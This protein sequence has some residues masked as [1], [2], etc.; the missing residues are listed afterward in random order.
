MG[1]MATSVLASQQRSRQEDLASLDAE[2]KRLQKRWGELAS[3]S[4]S[5]T[6]ASAQQADSELASNSRAT[7]IG[8]DLM[9]DADSWPLSTDQPTNLASSAITRRCDVD[10]FPAGI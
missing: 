5:D 3:N 8:E 1:S 10:S 9:L 6:K 7:A 4:E 2:A